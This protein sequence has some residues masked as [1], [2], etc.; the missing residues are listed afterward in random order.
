MDVLWCQG[1]QN[2][3]LSN[4]KLKSTPK[5]NDLVFYIQGV[6]TLLKSSV[7]LHAFKV[8]YDKVE[9]SAT[10]CYFYRLFPPYRTF[11]VT[12]SIRALYLSV[13]TSEINAR[14]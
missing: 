9:L 12:A 10:G 14:E 2:I 1:A 11:S 8:L 4:C 13:Y 5:T 6:K 3:G 7:L